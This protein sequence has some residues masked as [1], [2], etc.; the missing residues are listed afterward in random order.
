M[1]GLKTV[2]ICEECS[3]RS[4]KWMG[5]CPSCGAWNTFIE[6]VI[7]TSSGAVH[8]RELLGPTQ[9]LCRCARFLLQLYIFYKT[10]IG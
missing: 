10:V 7:D 6:D 3:Y 4:P 1:K 2:Y 9:F 5:K 8:H